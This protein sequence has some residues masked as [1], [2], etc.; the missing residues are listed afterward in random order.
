MDDILELLESVGKANKNIMVL[1]PEKLIYLLREDIEIIKDTGL[2]IFDEAHM[3]DDVS[4]GAQYEL[5]ISTIM[6]YLREDTQKLLLSAVIPNTVQIN[7]WFW[8]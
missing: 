1:T 2:I 7:D 8:K 4:R 6:M 5:L 3:F